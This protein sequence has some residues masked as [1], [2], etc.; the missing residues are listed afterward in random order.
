M[1]VPCLGLG[2]RANYLLLTKSDGFTPGPLVG[3]LPTL[4]GS[5]TGSVRVGVV[6][7]ID[8]LS[9]SLPLPRPGSEYLNLETIDPSSGVKTD[10]NLT[11]YKP[12][13][14]E[15]LKRISSVPES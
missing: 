4:R 13:T 12:V 1:V 9:L 15:V 6:L 14:L 7:V 8:P 3:V 11:I 5:E 2:V 10:D